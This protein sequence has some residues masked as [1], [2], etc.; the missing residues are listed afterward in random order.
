MLIDVENN[1]NGFKYIRLNSS[2]ITCQPF[3]SIPTI[4]II[5]HLN[6]YQKCFHLFAHAQNVAGL[7]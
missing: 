7:S 3:T 1:G 6:P 2:N 4:K 5:K